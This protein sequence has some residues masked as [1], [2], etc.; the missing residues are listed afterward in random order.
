MESPH[1]TQSRGSDSEVCSLIPSCLTVH[2]SLFRTV[3]DLVVEEFEIVDEDED[4]PQ[5][6]GCEIIDQMA[7]SMPK[8]RI[9]QPL[10]QV[11]AY[12]TTH[13]V[14]TLLRRPSGA[15][16]RVKILWNVKA[17]TSVSQSLRSTV[18]RK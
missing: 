9:F 1:Q 3:F 7:K 5:T 8:S 15:S 2:D 10:Y 16:S 11:F 4:T 17:V 12:E 14:F 18:R 6:L 13:H